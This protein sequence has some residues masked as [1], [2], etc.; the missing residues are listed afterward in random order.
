[1]NLVIKSRWRREGGKGE[2]GG[3]GGEEEES[4]R[5]GGGEAMEEGNKIYCR[6]E[7]F[8]SFDNYKLEF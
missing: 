8:Q 6:M 3:G 4:E 7:S 1:M 5:S 2:E